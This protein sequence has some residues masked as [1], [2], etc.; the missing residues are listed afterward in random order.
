MSIFL[1]ANCRVMENTAVSHYWI[2]KP[3]SPPLCS[4]CDPEI[5]EWH[6][7][8]ERKPIPPDHVVGPDGFV[9]HEKDLHL[10]SLLEERGSATKA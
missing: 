10:Q 2:R 4:A 7:V 8:F 3:N 9:Y 5:G 6:G 1:C